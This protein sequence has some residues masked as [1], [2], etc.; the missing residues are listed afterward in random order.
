MNKEPKNQKGQFS[1][2]NKNSTVVD[3]TATITLPYQ[4]DYNKICLEAC[5]FVNP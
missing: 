4:V 3:N 5:S 2:T 1:I